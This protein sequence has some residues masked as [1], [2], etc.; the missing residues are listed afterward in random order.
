M[1]VSS[2]RLAALAIELAQALALGER[3]LRDLE[4]GE[5]GLELEVGLRHGRGEDEPRGCRV[6][7]RRARLAERRGE[8]VA[9]LAPEVELVV[10]VERDPARVD[11]AAAERRRIDVVLAEALARHARVEIDGRVQGRARGVG[12]GAGGAHP[13]F[14][15]AQARVA[16][17][18]LLDERVELRV[19]EHRPPVGAR[20]VA[21][22][23][24]PVADRFLVEGKRS[25]LDRAFFAVDPG[26]ARAARE[27]EAVESR[28]SEIAARD[29]VESLPVGCRGVRCGDRRQFSAQRLHAGFRT[30]EYLLRR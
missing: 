29:T 16:R 13:R 21:R 30:A 9:V 14:G 23:E 8:L 17:E 10:E 20:P 28:M 24:D 19:A 18:R 27:R 7:G 15:G 11:P 2:P 5:V 12:E 1:P 22:R 4:R 3:L 6:G 25:R 26:V